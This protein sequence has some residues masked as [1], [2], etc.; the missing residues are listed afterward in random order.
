[1]NVT[2]P[3]IDRVKTVTWSH[4]TPHLQPHSPV[5][6]PIRSRGLS[7]CHVED[8]D[9][10]AESTEISQPFQNMTNTYYWMVHVWSIVTL[11]AMKYNLP[12]V[13]LYLR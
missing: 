13:H 5:L 2:R 11:N 8:E 9:S 3:Y 7:V 4:I 10:A 12:P 6:H 1:M